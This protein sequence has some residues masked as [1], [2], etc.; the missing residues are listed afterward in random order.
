MNEPSVWDLLARSPSPRHRPRQS[1]QHLLLRSGCATGWR[2]TSSCPLELLR[3]IDDRLEVG[4]PNDPL[5]DWLF[6]DWPGLEM[7]AR[8]EAIRRQKQALGAIVPTT[9]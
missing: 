2:F 7:K 5:P 3:D 4:G 1:A 6:E 8:I 9:A